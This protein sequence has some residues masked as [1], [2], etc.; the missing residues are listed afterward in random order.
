M[1]IYADVYPCLN[2]L[3]LKIGNKT[4]R[5]PNAVAVY[6]IGVYK[7]GLYKDPSYLNRTVTINGTVK[8]TVEKD[9]FLI[10]F[11]CYRICIT[12]Q[13]MAELLDLYKRL[14]LPLPVPE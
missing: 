8:V 3:C 6:L 1:C 12:Y 14:G 9:K 13:Q 5:L 2:T 7:Y 11:R 10:K 4:Y